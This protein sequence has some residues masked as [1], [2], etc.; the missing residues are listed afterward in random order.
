MKSK[1]SFYRERAEA[2]FTRDPEISTFRG[3]VNVVQVYYKQV[4]VT[5]RRS[6]EGRSSSTF[7]FCGMKYSQAHSSNDRN[8]RLCAILAIFFLNLHTL[9]DTKI[10]AA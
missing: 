7:I 3:I 1:V 9:E 10:F 8:D 2:G 6:S 4:F 5:K